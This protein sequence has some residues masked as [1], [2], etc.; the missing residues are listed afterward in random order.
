MYAYLKTKALFLNVCILACF[1]ISI[2]LWLGG[3]KNTLLKQQ[4][5]GKKMSSSISGV[6]V[7]GN[8]KQRVVLLA[9]PHKTSSSSI[10]LNMFH[11][12]NDDNH[13]SG[14]AQKWAWPSPSQTF[15]KDGC[16]VNN[17]SDE[18]QIFYWWIQ[19]MK[20]TTK[21][22]CLYPHDNE[23]PIYSREEMIETY[24]REFY[25][26]WMKGYNLVI[27]SEAMD[28][29]S[30]ERFENPHELL[31]NIIHQL[32]WHANYTISASGSDDDITVVV[33]YRAPRSSHLI[34]LWHQ[35]CMKDMSF[36][37]FLT[38]RRLEIMPD[39][40]KSLDSLKLTKTFLD[41]GLKV[42]LVDMAGVKANQY[43]MSNV[44][45]CDVLGAACTPD[46]RFS[47]SNK[48]EIPA[49][50]NVKTHSDANFDVTPKQLERI[51]TVIQ[52][53]D[54]NFVSLMDHENFEVL[55]AHGIKE[56]FDKCQ[57]YD[58][59]GDDDDDDDRVTSRKDMVQKIIAIAKD[60]Q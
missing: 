21:V 57:E 28:F 2:T 5:D 39:P 34:S 43:D 38:N 15:R 50:A 29:V 18:F 10:Q 45:A 44:I 16:E 14:L 7:N 1:T 37:E 24:K 58:D 26:Q 56:I 60:R 59:D 32:P 54:C 12:L 19:A 53:Y 4:H 48:N 6:T 51:D 41:R 31:E 40:L 46:K 3:E 27:A 36:H 30:S 20:G 33:S 11:W 25:E 35:C 17:A 42:I 47:D 49:I 9:G 23:I 13:A 52:K 55:Y 22:R 8:E